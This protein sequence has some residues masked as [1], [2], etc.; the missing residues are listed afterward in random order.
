[1]GS[2]I[3]LTSATRIV[4]SQQKETRF[5]FRI[6]IASR[7]ASY[8]NMGKWEGEQLYIKAIHS[9]ASTLYLIG[10]SGTW[11]RATAD[12]LRHILYLLAHFQL[13]E[14]LRI[15]PVEYGL[16]TR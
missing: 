15:A 10:C 2:M 1:M 7:I 4:P 8:V 9:L 11:K 14:R 13:L 12:V 16:L 6:K 3:R 5:F